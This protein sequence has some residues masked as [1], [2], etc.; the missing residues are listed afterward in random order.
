MAYEFTWLTLS[1]LVVSGVFAGFINTLAGGG[2]L[3]TLPALMLL[4]MPA[5]IANATNRVGVLLQSAEGMRGFNRY[6]MLAREAL[7]PILAPT[8]AGALAG[9]LIASYLPA[10]VLEPVLL[11]TLITMAVVIVVRPSMVAPPLGTPPLALRDAPSGYVWLFAAGVYGGFVQAGVGF[12]L[13][14]ALAGVLRYDLVRANALKVAA[15]AI[16]AVVALVVFVARD[17]V[18]SVKFAITVPQQVLRW[19]LLV[20]VVVVCVAAWLR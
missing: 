17:Q 15:T 19:F 1:I 14:A 2:S 3:L 9:S 18:L 6:G 20:M 10:T 16:F 8:V 12:V 4:G 13:L 5:D 11:I 7:V